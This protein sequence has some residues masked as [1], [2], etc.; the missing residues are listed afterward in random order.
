MSKRRRDAFGELLQATPTKWQ[1]FPD[2]FD[3]VVY[4]DEAPSTR[5]ILVRLPEGLGRELSQGAGASLEARVSGDTLIVERRA[6]KRRSARRR[7]P[8]V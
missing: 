8:R 5:R 3:L 7:S 1:E 6:S 4:E 2:G